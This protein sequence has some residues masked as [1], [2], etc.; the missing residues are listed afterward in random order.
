LSVF[1]FL[2]GSFLF[3]SFKIVNTPFLFIFLTDYENEH[4]LEADFDAEFGKMPR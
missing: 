2:S 3:F 4:R 1:V